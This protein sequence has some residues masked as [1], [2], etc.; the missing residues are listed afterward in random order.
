MQAG[1]KQINIK[2]SFLGELSPLTKVFPLS[3][4]FYN[5]DDCNRFFFFRSVNC[6]KGEDRDK[7]GFLYI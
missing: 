2:L 1:C 3:L 6:N 5:H 4:S 7:T